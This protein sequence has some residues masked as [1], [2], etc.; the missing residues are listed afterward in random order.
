M[1]DKTEL[2]T[3][4]PEVA[5]PDELLRNLP[6]IC[7]SVGVTVGILVLIGWS[8]QIEALTRILPGFVAMNPATAVVLTL[9]GFALWMS[10]A[11]NMFAQGAALAVM[12]IAGA[13]L[14]Q[15]IAGFPTGVDQMLFS[16][17]IDNMTDG[18]PNRM[19]PNT[20]LALFLLGGSILSNTLENRR[21]QLVAQLSAAGAATI[22]MFALIGYVLSIGHLYGIKAFIPMALHTAICI[23]FLAIGSLSKRPTILITILRDRGPAGSLARMVLPLSVL[24]PVAVGMARLAGQRAGFYGTEVGVALQVFANVVVLFLLLLGSAIALYRSDRARRIREVAVAR[25]EE[26][27]RLAEKVAHVG[28]WRLDVGKS[29]SWSDEVF[30]ILGIAKEQGVPDNT[31][32]LD[33]Y[34]PEDRAETRSELAHAL[35]TGEGWKNTRRVVRPDGEIR[36]VISQGVCEQAADGRVTAV[37]GV[38]ADVTELEKARHLA[39]EATQEKAAFLANMSHEIRTPLNSI[40]GFTDLLLEDGDLKPEHRRQLSLVQ[41]AGCSLLTVV[42]DILDFSKMGAGKIELESEPFAIVSLVDNTVSMVLGTA[43][44][45]GLEIVTA[46]APAISDYHIGDQNRVRQILLNL[47]NNAVKFT[48]AGTVTVDVASLSRDSASE[49]VRF[50][51]IDTGAGVAEDKQSRLFQQFSQADTSVSR[52]YGGTGLGLAISKSLVELMG[53]QIGVASKL[54]KGSTF[55]FEIELPISAAAPVLK[56][57]DAFAQ[58]GGRSILL[59]EDLPMNQELACALLT[60]VGH[61]VDVA[62]H[63]GEAIEAVRNK[64]YDLI[65]MD[66]QMPKVDGITATKAIRAMGGQIATIPIIAMTANVLPEQVRE[67]R[68]VGMDAHVAKPIKQSELY[69]AIAQILGER[70]DETEDGPSGNSGAEFD[71]AIFDKI[72]AIFPP[73]R[74]KVHL[75]SFDTQLGSLFEITDTEELR[76]IAHKLISQAGML[77]FTSISEISRSLEEA[78]ENGGEPQ[79]IL[80]EAKSAVETARLKIA[81]LAA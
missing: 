5:A 36:S 57:A 6:I 22:A 58:I 20:A 7:A 19:A 12:A 78:C 28:H 34:H 54:G 67:F 64:K 17:A 9:S 71:Q 76:G 65:L 70:Q 37:F 56:K 16:T 46:I 13:K 40:I 41:N 27:Y 33:L 73:D 51:V 49:R 10:P 31:E 66:I 2:A 18:L 8:L 48:Q 80:A 62:N 59:V 44:T 1:S 77:G 3:L 25:S 69:G 39:E 43:Q 75:A 35:K 63:G 68:R 74:L 47:L 32:I 23:L 4:E 15:L 53:G 14:I 60:R 79:D 50:S 45:K 52:E 38:F 30:H 72:A 29:V 81:E 24:V 55:W 42:N 11:K 61:Q 26:Q 21:L